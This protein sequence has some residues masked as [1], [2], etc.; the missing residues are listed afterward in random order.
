[1]SE[2]KFETMTLP[3]RRLGKDSWYP[4]IRELIKSEI[5]AELDEDDGLFIGY[6]MFSDNLPYTMQDSYDGD[7][8]KLTFRTAVLENKFLKAVFLPELGGRLWSLYDKENKRDLILRNTAFLPCNLGIRNAWFAGGV[9]FNCGRRGHDEQTCSPRFTAVV[10][11]KY[12]ALR[13]YEFQRDRNVVFQYD[14]F[15]PDD[16]HFLY[17]RGRIWNPT[18]ETLPMYWWSNIAMPELKG[19]RVVV[20]A[21]DVFANWYS[22]GSHFLEKLSMPDG[23]GFDASYPVNFEY[24]KDHFYNIPEDSRR[25][26][27]LFFP[28]GY[29]FCHTS[30]GVF[31]DVSYLCGGNRRAADTGIASYWGLIW[32]PI[33]RFKV[34]SAGHNRNVCP[35]RR[36]QLG[37]GLRLM[38]LSS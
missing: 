13:F 5:S 20:P 9:E 7:I 23:E 19:S 12:P 24:V 10:N 2:L 22:N 8:E 6:G 28:D 34:D 15:L 16:S 21:K 1:M 31:V 36:K 30:T 32:I 35:C 29:G 11:G 25:Y 37:S 18:A 38:D 3:G 26:E 17:I 27:C 33:L 4:G 14:C